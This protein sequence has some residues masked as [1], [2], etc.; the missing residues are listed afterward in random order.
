MVQEGVRQ[1]FVFLEKVGLVDVI[2]PFLISFA[3]LYGVFERVAIFGVDKKGEPNT[4][5]NMMVAG[6]ISLTFV[7]SLNLVLMMTKIIWVFT[8]VIVA[9]LFM[10]MLMGL[11][12][13]DLHS[14]F[15]KK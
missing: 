11:F 7:V 14:L 6:L 9:I 8:V 4:K 5:V 1:V 3:L 13:A 15:K 12:G 10:L 2:L